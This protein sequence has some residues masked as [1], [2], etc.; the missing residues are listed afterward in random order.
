[1]NEDTDNNML[2]ELKSRTVFELIYEFIV[3][4]YSESK[5]EL[6]LIKGEISKRNHGSSSFYFI[7]KAG[8]LNFSILFTEI[9]INRWEFFETGRR[10]IIFQV[11]AGLIIMLGLAALFGFLILIADLIVWKFVFLVLLLFL[12][13]PTVVKTYK[14]YRNFIN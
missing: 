8:V 7:L 14:D 6:D 2:R 11:I 3:W 13:Y 4:D 5:S 9:F 10:K 12:F 1:M